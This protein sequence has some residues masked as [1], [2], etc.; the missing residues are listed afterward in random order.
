MVYV[1]YTPSAYAHNYLGLRLGPDGAR[2]G[3]GDDDPQPPFETKPGRCHCSE[4]NGA[5][6]SVGLQDQWWNNT[7]IASSGQNFFKFNSCNNT[8]PLD[9]IIPYPIKDNRFFANSSYTVYCNGDTWNFTEA[10]AL[11]IDVG[12][13]TAPLPTLLQLIAM[14]HDVLQF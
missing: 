7:C 13:S 8:Y 5:F 10:Q 14:G 9:G 11:G 3:E 12:S 4:A 2:T 1:D 6:S